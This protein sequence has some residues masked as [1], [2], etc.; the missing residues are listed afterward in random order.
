M[1]H[2]FVFIGMR[3]RQGVALFIGTARGT[4]VGSSPLHR[5]CLFL[6]PTPHASVAET[7]IKSLLRHVKKQASVTRDMA[8]DSADGCFKEFG[9]NKGAPW[10]KKS[11][12][13]RAQCFAFSFVLSWL[14]LTF[15]T[16]LS[17]HGWGTELSLPARHLIFLPSPFFFFFFCISYRPVYCVHASRW[18]FFCGAWPIY[19]ALLII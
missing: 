16:A 9:S 15:F 4:C 19:K 10:W 5:H 17:V 8:P 13:L 3:E 14:V 2:D 7:E 6:S 18:C 12:T 11:N 1:G